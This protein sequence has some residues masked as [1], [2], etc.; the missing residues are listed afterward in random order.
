MLKGMR[1]VPQDAWPA[2]IWFS[3][4]G[5][6]EQGQFVCADML[7]K[8]FG[9]SVDIVDMKIEIV[10]GAPLLTKHVAEAP[11]LDQLR[12][13]NTRHEIARR[14]NTGFVPSLSQI[15]RVKYD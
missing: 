14:Q 3:K 5:T 8:V 12:N 6:L 9:T 15:E 10:P 7:S 11:W 2:F 4:D 13:A 1:P